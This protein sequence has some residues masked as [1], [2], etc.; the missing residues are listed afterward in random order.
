MPDAETPAVSEGGLLDGKIRYRQFTAGH[1]SGFEPVLLAASVP[2]SPGDY[3][4]EAGTGAGA[5]LLCLAQRV[6]AATGLGVEILQN[7]ADLANENFKINGLKAYTC[8]CSDIRQAGFG[9]VFDH[10]MANPPWHEATSSQSPDQTRALAHHAG[11]G[12]LEQ[13][14]SA[15]G[16]CL[17]PQGSLT[18]ILPASRY[19][20]A[21]ACLRQH[22][23]GATQLFPLWPRAEQS[24]K[25][26][27][28][29]ARRNAGGPDKILPGLVLHD[30]AGITAAAQAVLRGGG[31]TPL[32]NDTRMPAA[33][34]A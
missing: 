18:L 34:S 10:A 5:A 31:G 6:P 28:I 2:A 26:V 22:K 25:L 30:D 19:G 27:L 29:A 1:R 4:L 9:A 17:K 23:F 11:S 15:L 16:S 21:L 20:E 7:L 3:I 8:V 12:L 14:I 32:A 13:W 24:A 33:R